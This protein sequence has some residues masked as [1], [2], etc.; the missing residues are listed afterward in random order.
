[1]HAATG[2]CLCLI[3]L[4]LGPAVAPDAAVGESTDE[5]LELLEFLGDEDTVSEVWNGFFDSLPEGSEGTA[6]T[7]TVTDEPPTRP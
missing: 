4:V 3:G 2:L 1:M 5:L 6:P 7:P